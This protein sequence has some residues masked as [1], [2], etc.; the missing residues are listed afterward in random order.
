LEEFFRTSKAPW[1]IER[2]LLIAGLLENFSRPSSR[3][4]RVEPTPKLAIPYA[5]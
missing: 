5:A 1:P 3:S 2:N 4:G